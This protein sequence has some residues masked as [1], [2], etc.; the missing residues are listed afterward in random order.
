MNYYLERCSWKQ[1]KINQTWENFFKLANTKLLKIGETWQ[2]IKKDSRQQQGD[3]V[4]R[5]ILTKI[6]INLFW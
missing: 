6:I 1:F 3:I 5:Q 2:R 4:K